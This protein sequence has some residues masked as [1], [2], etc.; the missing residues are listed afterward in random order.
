MK[1]VATENKPA[2]APIQMPQNTS[3]YGPHSGSYPQSPADRDEEE[4]ETGESEADDIEGDERNPEGDGNKRKRGGNSLTLD[5]DEVSEIESEQEEDKVT[6]CLY[7]TSA[8]VLAGNLL[9]I[10]THF[11]IL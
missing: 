11:L 5:E 3:N 9:R 7:D 6:V 10:L 2:S 1:V 4:N 8:K